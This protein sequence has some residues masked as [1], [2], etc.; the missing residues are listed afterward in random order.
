MLTLHGS[1]PK[2]AAFFVPKLG[3]W[4]ATW[5]KWPTNSTE[6]TPD[7]MPHSCNSIDGP[8][9]DLRRRY[10]RPPDLLLVDRQIDE[11]GDNAERNRQI[12]YDVVAAGR[13][14]QQTAE[15]RAEKAA[16]LVR[17]ERKS[18]E[19]CKEADAEDL[20]DDSVRRRNGGQP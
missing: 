14:V 16:D 13:V 20:R 2:T 18:R 9:A 6:L 5:R 4:S 3:R 8:A 19:H 11:S 1:R 10:D 12:P 17:E 7:L 15:P